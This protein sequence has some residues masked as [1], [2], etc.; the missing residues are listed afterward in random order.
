MT[1]ECDQEAFDADGFA[2]KM[3]ASADVMERLQRYDAALLNAAEQQNLV[4]KNTLPIRWHR[5]YFDSAQLLAFIPDGVKTVCDLGSGA[6]FPGLVLA[7]FLMD[8]DIKITLIESTGK[9]ARFLQETAEAMGLSTVEV[10]S[11]RIEIFKPTE[12]PDVL[13][14]RA[15]APLAQLCTFAIRLIHEE[16]VCVFPKGAKAS[17]EL[18]EA[19]KHWTMTVRQRKSMTSDEATILTLKNLNYRH[20]R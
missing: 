15:L 4:S 18:H 2:E 11:E 13:T 6:G 7:A 12:K 10:I 1:D 8:R 19:R 9:K 16:T 5:H 20:A 17:E 14:A 3:D